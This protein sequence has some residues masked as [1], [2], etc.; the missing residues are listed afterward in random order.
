MIHWIFILLLA[1]TMVVT[2]T[3]GLK[4]DSLVRE[5]WIILIFCAMLVT[6]FILSAVEVRAPNRI[7]ILD[8]IIKHETKLV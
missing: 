4:P 6:T 1:L 8:L 5:N 2:T 7:E 3:T